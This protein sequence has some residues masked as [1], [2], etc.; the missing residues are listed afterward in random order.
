MINGH[1]GNIAD[2]LSLLQIADTQLPIG[3]YVHSYGLETYIQKG[4]IAN[5][6]QAQ[7]FLY[8]SLHNNTFYNDAAFVNEAHKYCSSGLFEKIIQLD[9][10]VNALKTPSE[11]RMA[12]K[13]LAARYMKIVQQFNLDGMVPLYHDAIQN[14]TIPGHHA[15]LFGIVAHA[16][17]ISREYA[18]AAYYY[19]T[20]SAIVT[21]CVK[22][23]PLG[24]VQGQKLLFESKFWIKSLVEK[25]DSV[26]PDEI[27]R[28]T[29]GF[30]I[31]AMQ[32]ER[33][34][35]RLYMS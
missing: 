32:H 5:Y 9:I 26:L 10:L 4:K 30:E 24:Q 2:F 28:C 8:Q 13:K 21:N 35:S 19:T 34:Y 14:D 27:G 6:G 22:M 23:V 11:I 25:A 31:H 7:E 33:L 20:A 1:P 29:P 18:L 17:H 3:G 12:S 15:V 16:M